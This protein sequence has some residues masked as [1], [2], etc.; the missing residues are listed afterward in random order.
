[1]PEEK[2]EKALGPIE[3]FVLKTLGKIMPG[4]TALDAKAMRLAVAHEKRYPAPYYP[5]VGEVS[6]LARPEWMPPAKK[7]AAKKA[8][9][10]AVKKAS[11]KKPAKKRAP[12]KRTPKKAGKKRASKKSKRNKRG[13]FLKKK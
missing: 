12:K 1:M 10:K 3:K 13:R 6:P 4:A 9:K 5:A 8:T 11:K 7:K 2:K